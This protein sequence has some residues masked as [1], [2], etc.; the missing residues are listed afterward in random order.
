MEKLLS[1]ALLDY[2][3]L[4]I[5]LILVILALVTTV[6][7]MIQTFNRRMED[8]KEREKL[9]EQRISSISDRLD[10]YIDNDHEALIDAIKDHAKAY[11]AQTRTLELLIQKLIQ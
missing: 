6:R 4:G 3:T 11:E 1:S 5:F 8:F 10:D 7:F 9:C 2:G